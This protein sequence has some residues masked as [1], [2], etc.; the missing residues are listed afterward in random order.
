MATAGSGAQL[1]DGELTELAFG[2]W[3]GFV[4]QCSQ[5]YHLKCV[6]LLSTKEKGEKKN[7]PKGVMLE[8]A[9]P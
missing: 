4:F 5:L 7:Q 1:L 9:L 8:A 6:H 2:W 3:L